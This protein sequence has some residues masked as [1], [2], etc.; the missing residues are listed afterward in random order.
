M[1][2]LCDGSLGCDCVTRRA[3]AKRKQQIK[4]GS[5][6][7]YRRCKCVVCKRGH[8]KRMRKYRNKEKN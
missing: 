4:H 5:A 7:M 3:V 1:Y 6:Y 8:A 2:L